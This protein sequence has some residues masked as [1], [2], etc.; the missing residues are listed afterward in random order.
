MGPARPAGPALLVEP[1]THHEIVGDGVSEAVTTLDPTYKVSVGTGACEEGA[2]PAVLDGRPGG[3][4]ILEYE[5][6]MVGPASQ[7]GVG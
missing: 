6:R 4:I 7:R 2:G 1:Y 5:T 3:E